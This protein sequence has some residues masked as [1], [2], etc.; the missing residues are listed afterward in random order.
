MSTD[1]IVQINNKIYNIN[2]LKRLKCLVCNDLAYP[3]LDTTFYRVTLSSY[4]ESI[5]SIEEYKPLLKQEYSSKYLCS[6]CLYELFSECPE[7][8]ITIE[9]IFFP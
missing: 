2:F 8:I 5:E 6:R 7:T 3:D 9:T 4:T 1:Q